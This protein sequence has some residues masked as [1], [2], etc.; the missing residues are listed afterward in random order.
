MA[1]P[2]DDDDM[3][4]AA[5]SRIVDYM[6]LMAYDQHDDTGPAGSVAGQGWFETALDQRMRDLAPSRTIVSIGSYAYDWNGG[7]ADDLSFEDAVIAA[8]DSEATI[9]FDDATNN[10]HFT[11]VEDDQ[12][13][14]N[15][16]FLDAVTAY[17]EIHASDIYRPAGYALW[18]LGSE[19]PSVWQVLGRIAMARRRSAEHLRRSRSAGDIDYEGQGEFLRVEAD[20]T[21]GTRKLEIDPT[22][23]D[24]DDEN[25]TRLPTNYIIRQ[26]G[27][28][29]G[30]I[31]LTFDDGPD[32]EWT[33]QILDILKAKHVKATFFIIGANAEA[34]PGLIQRILAEGHELGNHTYTHPNLADTPT[35][36][37]RSNSTRRSGCSKR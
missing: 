9:D 29:P 13:T 19:D 32:P 36:A 33:P 37:C 30:K 14:H 8:H 6:L 21:V 10:P 7:Q 18:R 1:A 5:Y 35:P 16:W 34:N 11:Y 17:N 28:V 3:P 22:T 23:G 4:Y 31:A 20:P 2:F 15:V 24:I 26:F 25:Y 12:T 27:Y